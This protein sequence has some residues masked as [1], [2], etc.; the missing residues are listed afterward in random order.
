MT[1]VKKKKIFDDNS[2]VWG[3]IVVVTGSFCKKANAGNELEIK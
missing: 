3:R 2:I 1:N